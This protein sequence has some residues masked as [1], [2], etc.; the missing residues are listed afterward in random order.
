[1]IQFYAILLEDMQRHCGTGSFCIT[2]S[3][4]LDA[5]RA[6]DGITHDGTVE[7]LSKRR[8]IIRE[9]EPITMRHPG[10]SLAP[11]MIAGFEDGGVLRL[12]GDAEDE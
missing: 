12:G 6:L 10:G 5:M 11:G 3:G 4:E 2:A 9:S 1:M 7:S 8:W